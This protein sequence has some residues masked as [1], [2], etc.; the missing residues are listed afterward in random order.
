MHITALCPFCRSAYQ[1]EAT[2]RGQL[3]R[4]PNAACRKSFTVPAEVPPAASAVQAAPP[5]PSP[6]PDNGPR[7]GS[8]ADFVPMLPA[9]QVPSSSQPSAA[10][11]HV[12]QMLPLA[13]TAPESGGQRN[14]GSWWQAAPPV[15]QTPSQQAARP[16]TAPSSPPPAEA[17]S[18]PE[19]ASGATA[20]PPAAETSWWSEAPPVR[21]PQIPV[22]QPQ[23]A[24]SKARHRTVDRPPAETQSMPAL[25]PQKTDQPR[26]LPPGVWVPPPVRRGSES[27]AEQATA[28]QE[29]PVHETHRPRLSK[30]RALLAT[31]GLL[32]FTVGVLGFVT[33]V[34]VRKIHHSEEEL[35]ANARTEYEQHSYSNASEMFGKLA[36]QFPNSE[37]VGEY[38]FMT[39][40][41]AVCSTV[42][43]PDAD[44]VAAAGRLNQYVKD[45]EKDPFMVQF[46]RDAGQLLLKLTKALAARTD[47]PP[48]EQPLQ[49][50]ERI[51]Q[52]RRTVAALGPDTLKKDENEQIDGDLG[53]V[54][55]AVEKSRKRREAIAR[56]HKRD[57]ETPMNAI[58]RV[59][60]LLGRMERELPGIGQDA[61]AQAALAQLYN[62]HLASVKYYEAA[63]EPHAPPPAPEEEGKRM[64]FAP[65]LP[66]ASPGT[67]PPNDPIVLALVR[68]VL[69]ALKQ[70]NGELKWAMP[71][72]IDTTVL[73][74]R[75]PASA[76][77]AEL[78]LVLSADTQTLTALGLDGNFLWEYHVGQPVLGRPILIEH[79]AYLADYSGWV[80]EIELSRG[81]LL[82]RWF[83]GQPLTRGGARES[84]TS[85]IYFPADDSC[86]YVLDVNP[87]SRR[88]VAILEDGHPSGSLRSEPILVPP[89]GDSTPGYL[90]LNQADGL[91]A[92]QLRVFELPLRDRHAAPWPLKPPARLSSGWSWFEPKEDSEKLTILS[93]AG[94]LGLFGIKQKGN[95]DQPLFPLLHPEGLDLSLFLNPPAT[96]VRGREVPRERGRAQVVH[97]QDDNLWVLA[98][99]RLQQMHLD[100]KPETGPQAAPVWKA[101]LTLGSPLHESQR[102]EE[103]NGRSSFFLVT[104]ALE[105]QTCL[106]TKVD[107]NGHIQ[108]KRQLGLVCQ[109]EPLE[110]TPPKGG[111]PLLLALDQGGGLFVLDTEQPQDWSKNSLAP[112]LAENPLV[113]PR[114]LPAE[115]GHSAY[116]IA[117]PGDGSKLI[118][119]HIYWADEVRELRFQEQEASLRAP[120]GK[121]VRTLAGPPALLGSQL[122][123]PMTDGN[124]MRLLLPDDR[125]LQ[126]GP[127]WR[128]SQASDTAPCHLLSLGGDRFLATD[129]S[130]GLKVWEWPTDKDKN[131]Q[132]LPKDVEGHT[133]LEHLVA[134]P[135][136]LLPAAAGQPPRVVVADS[137]GE[138]RLYVVKPDAT[139]QPGLLTWKFEGNLTAGPFIHAAADGWRIGCVLDRSRLLW[140]DPAK[141]DPLWTYSSDGPAILGQPR[142][143]QDMLVVALQSGRYVGIDPS[144]GQPIG[145]GY[146]LRTSAAPAATPMAFGHGQMFAPLSD[147]TALLLPLEL[148]KKANHRVTENTE[149]KNTEKKNTEKKNAEKKNN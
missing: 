66:T 56:L 48:D 73:P 77:S 110:L 61:E 141:D 126:T 39:E 60:L 80:H 148:L 117:A 31:I 81:Q 38:R 36:Q 111:P 45:H 104:Q 114:L 47:N 2:L 14:E 76:A 55:R 120:D 94:I 135:P 19:R 92:M 35:S 6:K 95:M 74:L 3:V 131:W 132:R 149:K 79:R 1:V 107:E 140:L 30:R 12:S 101:P 115:D 11:K 118:V 52:V 67:A 136:V 13:P 15:R 34:V 88:C 21:Q 143:I 50:V 58:K 7:S 142:Q 97:M 121:S 96:L 33:L 75:V 83:L 23:A 59:R 42:S 98:Q 99:G 106:A 16:P 68:G 124:V 32:L 116:E 145:P 43:D 72:G 40:W 146:T 82:G 8:V 69:Y 127:S 113:P 26:E 25:A 139:L 130:R 22:E 70:Y 147:G 86:I 144:T 46:G 9:E 87:K 10:S 137:A 65:L 17:R 108:W 71:V 57:D 27:S 4:C 89:E 28:V 49:A 78:L 122:L 85:L 84:D 64:L 41:C 123:M 105:Q 109:G 18:G 112:V 125:N 53:K 54:R 129:G 93:D 91:D 138:L 100:W 133:K 20:P 134:A 29:P 24:A 90:I 63:D 103:R 62:T 102:L 128:D 119:R 51:E 5:R 44:P 37:Q